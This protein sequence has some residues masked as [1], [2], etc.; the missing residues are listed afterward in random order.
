MSL[1]TFLKKFLFVK[2]CN[3]QKEQRSSKG[4]LY[5]SCGNQTIDTMV[6]KKLQFSRESNAERKT[7]AEPWCWGVSQGEASYNLSDLLAGKTGVTVDQ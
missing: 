6:A 4:T 5:P 3:C 2:L 7:L 1:Q